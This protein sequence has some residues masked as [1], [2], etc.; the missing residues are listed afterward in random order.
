MVGK[1]FHHEVL[2]DLF[3]QYTERLSITIVL[4]NRH[5]ELSADSIEYVLLG[6]PVRLEGVRRARM[7]AF[8]VY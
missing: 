1:S 7:A 3:V 2:H 8:V 4:E 5:M 6:K